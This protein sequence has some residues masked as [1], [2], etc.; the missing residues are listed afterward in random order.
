MKY[1]I[2]KF[3]KNK[4][5]DYSKLSS[6]QIIL[7]GKQKVYKYAKTK[8]CNKCFKELDSIK[9][10]YLKD[11][12][13]GRRANKCRDCTLEEQGVIEIGKTRMAMKIFKKG[14]RNCSTCRQI[15]PLNEFFKNAH[16]YGGIDNK[17][18]ACCIEIHEKYTKYFV[19]GKEFVTMRAFALYIKRSYG[20]PV[21]MTEARIRLGKG[22]EICKI[23][24]SHFRSLGKTKGKIRVTDTVNKKVFL[25]I[26]TRDK[27]LLKMMSGSTI[28][29][30]LKT[31]LPVGGYRGSFYKN[32]CLIERIK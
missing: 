25:F 6:H 2:E 31:G 7:R 8:A 1:S 19:D 17:C 21:S 24:E 22:T 15:K 23:S 14:F 32:P 16:E 11:S 27:R 10:F 18:K 30:G 13:T 9:E 5:E 28:T 29:R 12:K 4:N 3:P 20:N 26:N